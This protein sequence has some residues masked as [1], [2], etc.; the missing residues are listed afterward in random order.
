MACAFGQGG[1]TAFTLGPLSPCVLGFGKNR[2]ERAR[3]VLRAP[4]RALVQVCAGA[5]MKSGQVEWPL[6]T[7][8]AGPDA[9][10]LH[11]SAVTSLAW[12]LLP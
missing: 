6:S 9:G 8:G 3:G 1:Y 2:Q 7:R 4:G 12:N 10:V 5:R 11:V